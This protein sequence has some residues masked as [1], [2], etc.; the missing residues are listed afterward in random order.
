MTGDISALE[1][2]AVWEKYHLEKD[3]IS[4]KVRI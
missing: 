3:K 1:K 2:I 4:R